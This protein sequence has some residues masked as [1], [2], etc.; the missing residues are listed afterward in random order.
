MPAALGCARR[1][2]AAAAAGDARPQRRRTT[3]RLHAQPGACARP[4]DDRDLHRLL[5][6]PARAVSLPGAAV[7]EGVR[8]AGAARA[9]GY[10]PRGVLWTRRFAAARGVPAVARAGASSPAPFGSRLDADMRD[11]AVRRGTR[12]D[13]RLGL[14]RRSRSPRLRPSRRCWLP[15]RSADRAALHTTCDS[16]RARASA[17]TASS[18]S[19]TALAVARRRSTGSMRAALRQRRPPPRPGR[20]ARRR[21]SAIAASTTTPPASCSGVS[22]SCSSSH[23]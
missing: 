6:P 15:T 7:L 22:R 13:T 8:A 14:Q 3:D 2:L 5:A 19:V 23:A 1:A 16:W 20:R 12:P 21:A 18:P 11:S 4:R 9:R 10:V 17:I